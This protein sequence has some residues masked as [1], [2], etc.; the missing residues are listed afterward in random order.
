MGAG[1]TM[2]ATALSQTPKGERRGQLSNIFTLKCEE[3]EAAVTVLAE[4]KGWSDWQFIQG[5]L[6]SRHDPV[7]LHLLAL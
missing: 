3:K 1:N 4:T 6:Q 2:T 7:L 5:R